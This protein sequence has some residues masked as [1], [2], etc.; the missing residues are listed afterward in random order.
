MRRLTHERPSA[1]P[2]NASFLYRDRHPWS[3]GERPPLRGEFSVANG[4][5][6]QSDRAWPCRTPCNHARVLLPVR[7]A[8]LFAA[9][10]PVRP[11]DVARH[12]LSIRFFI[13]AYISNEP[14]HWRQPICRQRRRET[15]CKCSCEPRRPS[16]SPCLGDPPTPCML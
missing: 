13:H 15:P 7:T 12:M 8:Q 5:I 14:A 10:V 9:K 2:S 4:I 11:A 6:C 1:E 3:P 16:A